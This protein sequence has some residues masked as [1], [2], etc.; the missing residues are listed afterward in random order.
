MT[1][2]RTRGGE[3]RSDPLTGL[4]RTFSRTRGGESDVDGEHLAIG[5]FSPHARG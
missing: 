3:S 1:F 4:N 2:P 5:D